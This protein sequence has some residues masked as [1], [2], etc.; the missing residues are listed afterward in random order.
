MT[1]ASSLPVLWANCVER[2]KDRVNSRSFWEA[3]ESTHPIT[4]E[5]DTLIV[6]MDTMDMNRASH[7]QHSAHARTVSQVIEE[8]F[9]QPLQLRLIEGTTLADWEATKD[10]EARLAAMR[11]ATEM[12]QTA[13]ARP[14]APAG[15]SDPWEALAEQVT[16][17][18]SQTAN[19]ALPQN[20]ARYANEALYTL[21]E[22]MDTLYP[23]EPDDLAERGLARVLDRIA[24]NSEIPAPMLAFELERLRAWRKSAE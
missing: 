24:G 12:R 20:K 4:I 5:N 23:E 8:V 19:R 16:R 22:A 15:Y 21:V 13:T 2:L 10:R 9:H 14:L 3:V 18:Y 11:E 17:L 7:I 6:G 1:A